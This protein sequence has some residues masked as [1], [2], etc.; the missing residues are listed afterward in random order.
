MMKVNKVYLI[1]STFP[2][3]I[4]GIGDHTFYL[5]TELSKILEVKV[6][7]PIG[8]VKTF[9]KFKVEQIFNY[10]KPE[11]F[12]WIIK[13]IVADPP[14]WVV[15]QYDPFSY[16]TK[17]G[18]NPYIP[19]A[20]N[21]LKRIRPQIKIAVIVH[22]SFI[23]IT[24]Y[25][26]AIL[27]QF[28]KV[29]LRLVA[30]SVDIIFTVIEPWVSIL[31]NW[32]PNKLIQH[33]PVS[34]NIPQVLTDRDEVR[35]RLAITPQTIVLGLFGRIRR[36][37]RL[38]HIIRSVNLIRAAGFEVLVMYIGFDPAG[39]KSFLKDLPLLSEGPFPPEEISRRFAAMD[40]FLVPINEGVSTRN[41]SFMTGLQHGIPTVATLGP[42]TDRM[43]L[44]ENG[45]AML[46]VDA[47]SPDVFAKAVLE[48]V[49]NPLQRKLLSD[50]AKELFSRE[51]SWQQVSSRLLTT[52]SSIK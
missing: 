22:E 25:K 8:E 17:F 24:N 12:C 38:D 45:K 47:Q 49:I 9:P 40:I 46:L 21:M 41:T 50:G 31:N 3:Q 18:L 37:R 15:L 36:V 4:C 5:A 32:F 35:A 20:I 33:L 30:C 28:L 19:L 52:I 34:S 11:S 1:N 26:L 27:Q 48:L 39:A 10:V 42:S 7:V 2:P 16:G 43:L 23:D 51:F 6:L 44:Q 13:F 29:Q 14:D